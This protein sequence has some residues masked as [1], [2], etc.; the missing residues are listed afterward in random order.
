MWEIPSGTGM[1]VHKQTNTCCKD[2]GWFHK[3]VNPIS[4][5]IEVRWC[6]DESRATEDVYTDIVEIWVCNS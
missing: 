1:G 5:D 6:G 4:D 2:Y 3:E